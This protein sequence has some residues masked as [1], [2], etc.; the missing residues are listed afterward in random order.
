MY[1]DL[2][3]PRVLLLPAYRYSTED[4]YAVKSNYF[5]LEEVHLALT[6]ELTATQNLD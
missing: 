3:H 2:Y 4:A 1:A 6:L 5:L